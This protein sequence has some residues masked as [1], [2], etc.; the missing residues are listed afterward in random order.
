MQAAI[1]NAGE[2]GF[3]FVVRYEAGVMYVSLQSRGVA[4]ADEPLV[5]TVAQPYTYTM[6][7]SATQGVAYCPWCGCKLST[8]IEA[9]APRFAELAASHKQ[10]L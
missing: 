3:A 2:R 4:F 10:F 9:H 8:L 7:L 5:A 6:N 1:E